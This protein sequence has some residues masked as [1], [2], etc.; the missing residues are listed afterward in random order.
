MNPWIILGIILAWL[1]SITTVGYWQ[2]DAG[3]TAERVAWQ[4]RA[5]KE[6]AYANI[7]ITTLQDAYRAQEAAHAADLAAISKNYQQEKLRNEKTTEDRIAAARDGALVL[8]DPGAVSVQTCS[9]GVPETGA[10]HPGRDDAG[11]GGL[12]KVATEFLLNLTGRANGV[13]DKL[14]ACQAELMACTNR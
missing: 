4:E 5:N 11:D 3:H 8:R 12:S 14:T 6:L 9:G 2:N 10:A 1:A 7:E 13:R